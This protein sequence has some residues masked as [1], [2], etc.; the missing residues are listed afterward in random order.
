MK[1]IKVS[2]DNVSSFGLKNLNISWISY[3]FNKIY[4]IIIIFNL[5]FSVYLFIQYQKINLF[6]YELKNKTKENN[7]FD[8]N[9]EFN[10][11][12]IDVDMIG[13]KYPD[14]LYDKLKKDILNGKILSS[15]IDFLTQLQ[16]KLIYLEKEINVTKLNA[17]YT[18]R[19]LYLKNRNV[20]YDDAEIRE[21][22]DIINWLVIHKS[23]QL[24]GIASDKY[25]GCKYATMKIG[26]NL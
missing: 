10:K 16:I 13:V 1:K 25:L 26:K 4:T 9:I 2:N 17:F 20:K 23:T 11:S 24:K 18:S 15:I 22:N 21:F 19:T 8:N 7:L 3:I 5:L 14:I 6:I 12:E